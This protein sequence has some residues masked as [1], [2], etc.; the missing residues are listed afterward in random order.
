MRPCFNKE[1][2]H[3]GNMCDGLR[4]GEKCY[5][6]KGEEVGMKGLIE[7]EGDAGDPCAFLVSE[8]V[9]IGYNS[10]GFVALLLKTGERV[11]IST[12]CKVALQRLKEAL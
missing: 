7:L 10:D 3:L 9:G 2:V 11:T 1:C 5:L 8:T 12:P 6:F 4:E